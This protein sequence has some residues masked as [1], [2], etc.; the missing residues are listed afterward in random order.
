MKINYSLIFLHN[1][2]FE[3]DGGSPGNGRPDEGVQRVH[4]Y[5]HGLKRHRIAKNPG[6]TPTAEFYK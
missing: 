3:L 1:G 2:N 5:A 6:N 4:M